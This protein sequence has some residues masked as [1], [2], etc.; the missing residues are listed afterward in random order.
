MSK[1]KFEGQLKGGIRQLSLLVLVALVF[2]PLQAEDFEAKPTLKASEILPPELLRSDLHQVAEAVPNDGYMNTYT[3]QSDF[4]EFTAYGM[5][6]LRMRVQEVSALDELSRVKKSDLYTEA[7][8][9]A[10][11]MPVKAVGVFVTQPVDTVKGLPAGVGRMFRGFGRTAESVTEDMAKSDEEEGAE[12]EEQGEKKE[13]D[14][15]MYAKK[16]MGVGSAQ[17]KWAGKLSVDPYSSNQVLQERLGEVA[18]VDASANFGAKLLMPGMGAFNLVA[19]ASNMVWNIDPA[20]LREQNFNRLQEQGVSEAQIETF[21]DNSMYSPTLQ[22]I[23]ITSLLDME[24]VE[25]RIVALEKA[26]WANSEGMAF[27]FAN[28]VRMLAAFH[29]SQ[30]G[31][32]SLTGDGPVVGGLTHDKRLV[33]VVPTDHLVWTEEFAGLVDGQLKQV[34]ATAGVGKSEFWLA[35]TA[36]PRAV[37]E[38][39]KRGWVV[40][41]QVKAP[42]LPKDE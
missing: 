25:N 38:L 13:S 21:L 11:M 15:E 19:S 42:S 41:Q 39:G 17:R 4:G 33:Y 35:G 5:T 36:T 30:G 12:G 6:L 7:A 40:H 2:S 8:T 22:T 37:Q 16:F 18:S 34:A 10:V 23:M 27:F 14:A 28:T 32:A 26:N 3:V 31:L 24:G 20:E 29:S 9:N 1:H